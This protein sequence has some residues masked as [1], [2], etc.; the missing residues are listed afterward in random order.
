MAQEGDGDVPGTRGRKVQ[1]QPWWDMC[2]V[3]TSIPS[4]CSGRDG[5]RRDM[6]VTPGRWEV[7]ALAGHSGEFPG[8]SYS[9]APG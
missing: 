2:S 3:L 5:H 4:S 8:S 6:V 7:P 9:P 1:G